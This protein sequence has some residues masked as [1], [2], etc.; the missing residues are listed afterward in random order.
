MTED[1]PEAPI[2]LKAIF[3]ATYE[4]KE[5]KNLPD[6]LYG[7]DRYFY[8]DIVQWPDSETM[9]K[10]IM[11][12]NLAVWSIRIPACA[13]NDVMRK[14]LRKLKLEDKDRALDLDDTGVFNPRSRLLSLETQFVKEEDVRGEQ[15]F[16]IVKR[17][18]WCP[19]RGKET[20]FDGL[21]DGR[22]TLKGSK[23][24]WD[25]EAEWED[26][27]SMDEV[28]QIVEG[29]L[30]HSGLFEWFKEPKLKKNGPGTGE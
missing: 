12:R 8:E 15:S 14:T 2:K 5:D 4:L 1:P 3:V 17:F 30:K 6:P 18:T 16:D 9:I 29:S 24:H 23:V 10:K 13:L 11:A 20:K 27:M 21:F 25:K 19:S 26:P 7:G 28:D 22:D